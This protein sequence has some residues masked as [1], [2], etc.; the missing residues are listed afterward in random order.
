MSS[1]V[2]ADVLKFLAD[3]H[4]THGESVEYGWFWFR[5]ILEDGRVDLETLDCKAMAS[6]TRDFHHVEE[7]HLA[8]MDVLARERERIVEPGWCT[9]A[10]AAVVST[11]LMSG[12]PTVF[13]VRDG[14]IV[15][16]KSGWYVGTT[17][18]TRNPDDAS[19]Y[20]MKS[21]YELS[22][23]DRRLLPYWLLPVGYEIYFDRAEPRVVAPKKSDER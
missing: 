9:L 16:S 5:A 17:D 12:H 21:L 8:Q 20:E 22:I 1:R 10:H 2:R 4:V 13:M 23:S 15:G 7:I 11:S 19:T 18:D 6:F 14:P 3:R